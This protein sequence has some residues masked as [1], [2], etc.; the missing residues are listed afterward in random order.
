MEGLYSLYRHRLFNFENVA[1][2]FV[3]FLIYISLMQI[4]ISSF[5]EILGIVFFFIFQVQLITI[6]I[7][8]NW[9]PILQILPIR[10]KDYFNA[11]M[12][13]T[14]VFYVLYVLCTIW[15]HTL[16]SKLSLL[17]VVAPIGC[18]YYCLRNFK[19]MTT[20]KS[21]HMIIRYVLF[22]IAALVFT[23]IRNNTEITNSIVVFGN[24]ICLAIVAILL[25]ACMY[26]IGKEKSL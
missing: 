19:T 15:F 17:F 5:Q 24:L 11:Y 2:D 13:L 7:D 12:K 25:F 26:E 23:W 3:I 6:L 16:I 14:F 22:M 9:N 10:K 8:E 1:I 4:P 20:I 21:N 18:L